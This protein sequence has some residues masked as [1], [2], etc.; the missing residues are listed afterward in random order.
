MKP[1]TLRLLLALDGSPASMAAARCWAGWEAPDVRLATTLLA[2]IDDRE[3]DAGASGRTPAAALATV[4]AWFAAAGL[5]SET[6]RVGNANPAAA[7]IDEARR[8]QVDLVAM[9]TRGLSPWR[10][11]LL[12]SVAAEVARNSTV[13]LWLT[14][15]QAAIPA[16][17][18]RHL[19]VL[20]AVDGS[21]Q[22]G[23]AAAWL[24]AM[25]DRLGISAIELLSVQPAFSPIEGLLDAVAGEFRH[26]GQESGRTAVADARRQLADL[27][28]L[29]SDTVLT[30]DAAATILAQAAER[31][32]DLIVLA[33]QGTN[34][35]AQAVLGSVTLTVLEQA[36]CPVLVVPPPR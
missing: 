18:G 15:P 17:L 11:L 20:L 7:I 2:V 23:Q 31:A 22:A 9:G 26:W 13:P 10:G 25:G 4:G 35:L 24:G 3:P 30:G 34:A 33:P 29:A 8:R 12:G 19:R 28:R 1:Q 6:L 32:A 16:A 27:G 21:A 36:T 14:G 5:A